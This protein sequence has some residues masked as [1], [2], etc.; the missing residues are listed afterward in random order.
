VTAAPD[1]KPT[2][3]LRTLLPTIIPSIVVGV[4]SALS[5]MGLTWI[6]DRLEDLLW[7]TIPGDLGLDGSSP[8]WIVLILTL[9]GFA[10]GLIITFVPGHA[11]PD[12]ATPNR[13]S[14][15]SSCPASP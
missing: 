3:P 13:P 7:T 11:G 8:L 2:S 4:A 9:T 12:P 5:L 14:R 6:A 10:V 1:A 15:R